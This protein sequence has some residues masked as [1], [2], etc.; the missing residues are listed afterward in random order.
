MQLH[1]D[2]YGYAVFLHPLWLIFCCLIGGAVHWILMGQRRLK[3]IGFARFS[4]MLGLG[5]RPADLVE[6][7]LFLLFGTV[8]TFVLTHPATAAQ[9]LTGGLGWT[10]LIVKYK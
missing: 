10:T 4:S 5:G 1:A 3:A 9:S 8:I 2:W 6:F 7:L